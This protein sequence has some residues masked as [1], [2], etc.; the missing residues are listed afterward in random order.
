MSTWQNGFK[1]PISFLTL[2]SAI[3]D[4]LLLESGDIIVLQQTGDSTSLWNN[5]IK[6]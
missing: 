1:S 3:T 6:H 2:E 4:F 5:T